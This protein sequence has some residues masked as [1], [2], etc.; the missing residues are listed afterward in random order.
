MILLGGSYCTMLVVSSA[1]SSCVCR[2]S[3]GQFKGADEGTRSV[4]LGAGRFV[5]GGGRAHGDGRLSQREEGEEKEEEMEG[6]R[7]WYYIIL[8]RGWNV[9][10]RSWWSAML[11]QASYGGL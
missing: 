7:W 1:S 11:N 6:C 10:W 3:K 2:N 4:Q 5:G 9:C 8:A